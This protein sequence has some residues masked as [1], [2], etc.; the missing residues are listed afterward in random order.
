[1][2]V[3]NGAG[4][5]VWLTTN[6]Q[7]HDSSPPT[8]D[9]AL[10]I[11]FEDGA[12]DLDY[13]TNTTH[14][15]CAFRI[16][17][18]HTGVANVTLEFVTSIDGNEHVLDTVEMGTEP[19]PQVV[20]RPVPEQ[21]SPLVPGRAVWTRIVS[22]NNP[23]LRAS[24]T[25]DRWTPDITP[26]V[27]TALPTDGIEADV[28]ALYQFTA[29]SL[30]ACWETVDEES[31]V[32]HYLIS[33]RL[34]GAGNPA[35]ADW[36]P[37]PRS[38]SAGAG[39]RSG[40][41]FVTGVTCAWT[42]GFQVVQ[43]ETYQVLVRAVNPLGL[44][45]QAN[46]SG[47]TVDWTPPVVGRVTIG[48]N[49]AAGV[50]SPA[51]ASRDSVTVAWTNITEPNT[52]LTS[53]RVGLG[54]RP[55]LDDV[56]PR[57]SVVAGGADVDDLSGPRDGGVHTLSGLQLRD[58]SSVF[59]SV[60]TTNVVG[61]RTRRSSERMLIDGSPPIF[62]ELP[63]IPFVPNYAFPIGF[64]DQETYPDSVSGSSLIVPVNSFL[65]PHSSITRLTV[66]AYQSTS[67]PAVAAGVEEGALLPP[68]FTM[69]GATVL[70]GPVDADISEGLLSTR[71]AGVTLTNNTFV[72]IDVTAT[73]GMGMTLR[74]LSRPVPI[75]TET[76]TA[77]FVN[78]GHL[79]YTTADDV[80]YQH[81]I[82]SY[83]ARWAGFTDPRSE[84][85]YSI[86]LGTSVGAAD[87]MDWRDVGQAT[88]FDLLENFTVP[89]GTTVYA[90]VEARNDVDVRVN[91]SSDGIVLGSNPPVVGDVAFDSASFAETGVVYSVPGPIS[92]V[93]NASDEQGVASCYVEVRESEGGA[94]L[95]SATTDADTRRFE[96]DVSFPEG[97]TLHATVSCANI[98]ERET[99]SLAPTWAVVET[100]PPEA[101]TV[102][103][104][105]SSLA[106]T[107]G[108]VTWQS[109][110]THASALWFGFHD[111]QSDI[112]SFTACL[113]TPKQECSVLTQTTA[114]ATN[115]EV[116]DLALEEGATYVWTVTA[117]SGAGETVV[118]RSSGW[119]VDTTPP[120][121]S[122][123]F[124]V[125]AWAKVGESVAQDIDSATDVS[126]YE[127]SWGGIEDEVSGIDHFTVRLGWSSGDDDVAPRVTLPAGTWRY[128]FMGIA[129]TI[130]SG[131]HVYA[132]LAAVDRAGNEVELFSDGVFF[133]DSPPVV[134]DV[135]HAIVE[136]SVNSTA[137][138]GR[139]ALDVDIL[140]HTEF[141]VSWLAFADAETGIDRYEVQVEDVTTPSAEVVLEWASVGNATTFAH[142]ALPLVHTHTYAVRVR[143]F[144]GAG[145]FSEITS[146]GVAI[147]LTPPQRGVVSDGGLHSDGDVSITAVVGAVSAH[148]EPFPEPDSS[149]DHYVWCVGSAPGKQD[150]V[151][152]HDVGLDLAATARVGA[153][154]QSANDASPV[155]DVAALL[156]D[157]YGD[158]V[159]TAAAADGGVLPNGRL[160]P[161]VI[162]LIPATNTH[163]AVY[164]STVTAVSE[165][166]LEMTS[167]SNGV[168]VDVQPPN[169]GMVLDGETADEED[170]DVQTSLTSLDV[171]W[172]G[173]SEFQTTLEYFTVSAGTTPGAND[174]VAG[175][176][177]EAGASSH[178]LDGLSL[179]NGATYFVTLSAFDEG[180]LVSA[181][182]TD[183]VLVDATPPEVLYVHDADP[184]DVNAPGEV[185]QSTANSTLVLAWAFEDDESG[186]QSYRVRVCPVLPVD[187]AAGTTATGASRGFAPCVLEWTDV[188]LQSRLVMTSPALLPG[189]RY[190]AEVEA[191]SGSGLAASAVSPGFFVDAT[192]P[193]EGTVTV[194]DADALTNALAAAGDSGAEE[195]DAITL[196]STWEQ[197]GV[198]WTGFVDQESEVVSYAV[199]VG[200]SPLA[201]DLVPCHDVGLVHATVI[202]AS[203]AT[204]Y[205]PNGA[206]PVEFRA[207]RGNFTNLHVTV[208]ARNA[209]NLTVEG[210][211]AAVQV[212]ASAPVAGRVFSGPDGEDR[213]YSSHP[214]DLCV[215]VE[216][217]YDLESDIAGY[218]VC[219]GSQPGQ[220]N[221]A[222]F[223]HAHIEQGGAGESASDSTEEAAAE[224]Q[225][226]EASYD[227]LC[228]RGITLRHR[229]AVYAT[230]RATNGAGLTSLV[231]STK[232]LPVLQDPPVGIV[233]DA[234]LDE[235]DA[236]VDSSVD[237]STY[238][239]RRAV[240][241]AWW[242]FGNG[243]APIVS[244]AVAVCGVVSGCNNE[245]N[246]VSFFADIGLRRNLT[247][248]S[249]GFTEGEVYK[250]HVR[251]TDA[252]GRSS[253]AVSD[254]FMID[255]TPPTPGT[256]EVLS[257]GAATATLNTGGV[258]FTAGAE[259]LNAADAALAASLVNTARASGTPMWH[260]GFAPLH[261]SWAGFGDAESGVVS[262][263]VCV[264]S[265]A[266][267]TDDIA[268]CKTLAAATSYVV[269]G[270]GDVN[271][272][273]VAVAE[274]AAAEAAA[275]AK[276]GADDVE[277]EE[278]LI[279][280][281]TGLVPDVEEPTEVSAA[282]S[283]IVAVHACNAVGHCTSRF[284]LPVQVDFSPP[285][286]GFISATLPSA[287]FTVDASEA[288]V[289]STSDAHAWHATWDEWGDSESGVAYYTVAVVDVVSGE[290]VL[291]HVHV[292]LGL[293]FS[294]SRLSLEHGHEYATEVTAYNY[295]GLSAT[296]RSATTIVDLT[297][298]VLGWIHDIFDL[299]EEGEEDADAS[300]SVVDADYGDADEAYIQASWGG[301][302]DAESG[303]DSLTYEWAAM[304]I[305]PR[306]AN[307]ISAKEPGSLLRSAVA[308]FLRVNG[309]TL[310]LPDRQY[311][312]G[313]AHRLYEAENGLLFTDWLAVG[314]ATSASRGD[315]DI[316]T[317]ATYV[318]LL[319]VTNGA[320]LQTLAS[321]DGIVFDRSDPCINRP[322][323]G[324]DPD[325]V[326]RYLN[327]RGQLS[328][329]WRANMDPL[330]IHDAEFECLTFAESA[331][332]SIDPD[333]LPAGEVGS[334]DANANSTATVEIIDVPVV[335]LSHMEWQLR[336]VVENRNS[337]GVGAS[338]GSISEAARANGEDDDVTPVANATGLDVDAD[339]NGT[340]TNGTIVDTPVQNLNNVS[341]S[342]VVMDLVQAG[343]KYASPWSGCCSSYSE[344]NPLVVNEEW[345]W[346]PV[347][348]RAKYFGH[349]LDVVRGR[350]V[351]VSGVASASVFDVLHPQSSQHSVDAAD[352]ATAAGVAS[353][354][355]GAD[356]EVVRV[357]GDDIL[358]LVTPRAL[359]VRSLPGA[360]PHEVALDAFGEL[361]HDEAGLDTLAALL[362]TAS[363]L[364]GVTASG[365]VFAG[366][367]FL[368]QVATVDR[369]VAVSLD[370]VLGAV[371]ARGVAVF[372]VSADGTVA[373]V[374]VTA[375]TV[376]SYAESL[377]MFTTP[378]GDVVLAVGSPGV[379]VRD[380]VAAS[381][382]SFVADAAS[383][384]TPCTAA[385]TAGDTK[386]VHLHTVTPTALSNATSLFGEDDASPL[387]GSSI[388]ASGGIVAVGD[389]NARAGRGRVT[390]FALG[391]DGAAPA[392]LCS[393][394]GAVAD[395]GHGYS[396][397][398]VA[399]AAEGQDDDRNAG[400][401]LVVAG[402]P[403]ANLATVLR[404]NVTAH[405]EGLTGAAVC[406]AV[407]AVRQSAS[408]NGDEATAAQPLY[409]AGT[410]VAVGGGMVLFASP[411]TDTW[412]P[413]NGSSAAPG[414]GRVFGASFCWS[415][416]VRRATIAS[417]ANIPSVCVPCVNTDESQ[418][419][420]WS[421]GGIATVCESCGDRQCRS[422]EDGNVF[423][424]VNNSAPLENGEEY[425]V[426]VTA[427]SRSGRRNT[428]TSPLF[429]VDWTP[430]E[431]G[432]VQDAFVGNK[433]TCLYCGDDLDVNTNATYLAASWCC[434]WQ[435]LESGI[436]SYSV[437]FGTSMDD[438]NIMNY[439]SVGLNESFVLHGVT[440]MNG[441]RYYACVIA[442]N[443]AGLFSEPGCSDGF[444]YDDTPPSMLHVYDG[445]RR[446]YDVDAQSFL[447]VIIENHAG[448]DNE[449]DII[450]YV[451]SLGLTP[452]GDEL[453]LEE[454]GGNATLNGVINRPFRRA[455]QEGDTVYANI[456]AINL[457]GLSSPLMSSNGVTIGKSEVTLNKESKSTISLDTQYA[458]PKGNS[459]V[460]G[461]ITEEP[462]KTL[463]AVDFPA[464]AV[465]GEETT[466][467]GGA[468]TPEDVASGNAINASETPPPAQ[469]LKFGD[470]SY[471]RGVAVLCRA[472]VAPVCT[473]HPSVAY[474]YV[475]VHAEGQEARRR[476]AGGLPVRQAHHHLD[477]VLCEGHLGRH[478]CPHGL[479][480]DADHLRRRHE[481]LD[482]RQEHLS[483]RD[484]LG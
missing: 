13:S 86:C 222:A 458:Q 39:H 189:V 382:A 240:G 125:D 111:E 453:L 287:D 285:V 434:G 193:S 342:T 271:Q 374:G 344:L 172:L 16:S 331:A 22:S 424:A 82:S 64:N 472:A 266:N 220:C 77:G 451:F 127:V 147:D 214:T 6:G 314:N 330:H 294:T 196:Q 65:D 4:T 388:A 96:W 359:E 60:W 299:D 291:P 292:G 120:D 256:V 202:N 387:F 91:A 239:Q 124:I 328:A 368:G 286:S 154:D 47:I 67:D 48:D 145:L 404:V 390:V 100:T 347:V 433:S 411:F 426:D 9:Y 150:V 440:L 456:R 466:F 254:G 80:A 87:L 192:P 318:V 284:A 117:E 386:V 441:Q 484:A 245:D 442:L 149:I 269:F 300:A 327:V 161:E 279:D 88:E 465:S 225:P 137:A 483:S 85:W 322:H 257:V 321:S 419:S 188:G 389:A 319:R 152:C 178:S 376:P 106:A 298:P 131:G 448:R 396:V 159:A 21:W 409:G 479:G 54:S 200:S 277:L 270:P 339:V 290:L 182:T 445:L 58:G 57:T 165:V 45:S 457:V 454:S 23:G 435:D 476:C 46:T 283:A 95:L 223:Q 341:D 1:M 397:D 153:M 148:W 325:V 361:A 310:D 477:A 169:S 358:A 268:P 146:D 422:L 393:V 415:G 44:W 162:A 113:G 138:A 151:P 443:G 203:A 218:D 248:A 467:T 305:D 371:A 50:N 221:V 94:V 84:I 384:G 323:A 317:G 377:A 98:R 211:S 353:P 68:G 250:W 471:V 141:R 34:A 228:A 432:W 338:S 51:Q 25:T 392:K 19:V 428:Q 179:T 236:V 107:S 175:V 69:A 273:A 155:A 232:V 55:G 184:D 201:S 121:V 410:S 414:T 213:L 190:E 114:Q 301:W 102:W 372:T 31:Q 296:A 307:P 346:R 302:Q 70:V 243:A 421:A 123:A 244:Y 212:D 429:K 37:V 460:N 56:V 219:L 90:T 7:V 450:D 217:F 32:D 436:V 92:V 183:G 405:G 438:M 430:P 265:A 403:A 12:L 357:V 463:A 247:L 207:R 43:G 133:D 261:V 74:T 326:P 206:E 402:S 455:P 8:L 365:A 158:E 36:A 345:G 481:D 320:G 126:F 362:P 262:Y 103:D 238:G 78:D 329:V 253:T 197:V 255:T 24:Y 378:N 449:T 423:T 475:Q 444:V 282:F 226:T 173:W 469:N 204:A 33:A 316:I 280:P 373:P 356:N 464:G 335:P 112:A 115:I 252:S 332:G 140:P 18:P 431:L 311:G 35:L 66:T 275:A 350:F 122:G 340:V 309:K 308:E 482:P 324:L 406:Q 160:A 210:V 163:M 306:Q 73:N 263:R 167:Y 297:P 313:H 144:N 418:P 93:W 157:A 437:A 470:Y 420:Y 241:A 119:T 109:N 360:L 177:V 375:S 401:A 394:S 363:A 49:A 174:V 380:A 14:W 195:L 267:Y 101:G 395:G 246:P 194:V 5:F 52:P 41:P 289:E 118:S 281:E 10:D 89:R 135:E 379:C 258:N 136:T 233:I 229:R 337:S 40:F 110:A 108:D 249:L 180:G 349:G 15:G 142:S 166:G 83:S 27:F 399:A 53:V 171:A 251:A 369:Y 143:G 416:H 187:G 304:V 139:H 234:A 30:G 400:T 216:G 3:E 468:V 116:S 42:S 333:A 425:E 473:H 235:E 315:V 336:R 474:V 412:R 2:Y 130:S 427:V 132:T 99:T 61:L 134:P 209:A 29:G 224:E 129:D 17:D 104:G 28:D 370:G 355:T 312:T 181:N 231:S 391:S 186:V 185:R 72:W 364:S 230:V 71:I 79:G 168:R 11:V 227:R 264:A 156:R 293:T 176:R 63:H 276:P 447:N 274:V 76:L 452:G 352:I 459:S 237:V 354:D 439:T 81:S 198:Q 461:A 381:N 128:A 208:I 205:M 480:A 408:F 272:T 260:A 407:A 62:L 351:A 242:G 413:V 295:A 97:Q 38:A 417:Q 59:A 170:V 343:P 259:G 348:P 288:Q 462:P 398:V 164:Y 105:A 26:P 366:V 367:R 191:T 478:R 383:Y 278:A 215:S 334:A 303:R 199:C 385:S 75:S 20:V 446:G